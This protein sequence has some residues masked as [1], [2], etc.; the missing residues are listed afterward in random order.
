MPRQDHRLARW[1][2]GL[3]WRVVLGAALSLVYFYGVIMPLD[4]LPGP[5]A[6][7]HA[8][9]Y[10]DIP[11]GLLNFILPVAWQPGTSIMFSNRTNC[12][13]GSLAYER[14]RYLAVGIPAWT[15]LFYSITGVAALVRGLKGRLHH[16]MAASGA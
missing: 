10:L 8:V 2:L 1:A 3:A 16:R 9:V 7:H 12:F 4:A 5:R 14:M 6:L 15:L 13:P 11:V